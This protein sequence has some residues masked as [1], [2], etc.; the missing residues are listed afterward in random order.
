MCQ[1]TNRPFDAD[2]MEHGHNN[3]GSSWPLPSFDLALEKQEW[4]IA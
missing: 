4:Q 2:S 3:Q 1:L